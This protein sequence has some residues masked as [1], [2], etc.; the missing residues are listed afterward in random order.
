MSVVDGHLHVFRAASARY[1]RDVHPLFPAEREATVDDLLA[2]MEAAGVE[3]A[4]LVPLSPHDGYV[5]ECLERHPGRF[6]AI[7]I[8]DPSSL[9]VEEFRR[10][11][12]TA[13]LQ[14][15][16]LFSLGDAEVGD[17][18]ALPSFP[19]LAALADGGHKLWF[20]S[21]PDQ[22]ALLERVL[23][24]L[25]HLAVVLNHLGFCPG[26]GPMGVDEWGRPRFELDLPASTLPRVLS[27][28]RFRG[29]HV[30]FSGEYAFS[31]E[32]YPYDDLTGTVRA[33]YDAYGADRMLRASDFPWI[34]DEPGYAETLALVDH[35]LPDL[36]EDERAAIR[37]GTATRLF[38]GS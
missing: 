37:G 19:L 32:R 10:R 25:P 12:E 35:F 26:L 22:L 1:P 23:E 18:E 31:Q 2:R 21:T 27:L 15:L 17:V 38:W 9:S 36:G 3:R 28:R 16:R 14:G 33:V 30:M 24:R 34:V 5:R 8:Q 4:V 13:G 29:V 20:Y 6:A 7:G 11:V